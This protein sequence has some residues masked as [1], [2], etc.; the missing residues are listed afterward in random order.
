MKVMWILLASLVLVSL[1]AYFGVYYWLCN[2]GGEKVPPPSGSLP[3]SVSLLRQHVTALVSVKPARHAGNVA[4]LDKAADYIRS[5]WTTM[6]YKTKDQVFKI[7]S[8]TYRNVQTFAGPEAGPRIV[9]GAHYDVCGNQPGA[10]DN[11][12]GVAGLL[13]LSRLIKTLKPKLKY[14]IDLVAYTLEEPPH[15]GT[16]QMG[17]AVHAAELKRSGVDIIAMISLEMIGYFSNTPGSQEYPIGLLSL[18]YPTVGNF[19]A[20]VGNQTSSGRRLTQQIRQGMVSASSLPVFSLNGPSGLTGIDF[21]DHRNYWAQGFPAVM[22]TDT[23]FFRNK[24]YHQPTD[25]IDTLQFD[26][27]SQVVKGV[28]WATLNL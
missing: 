10:D 12:S 15:F 25:T 6:G 16:H 19:I 17:S 2:P 8:K 27:M 4:S 26:K 1:V 24:N 9:I 3:V 11:A 21:S 5:Q 7:G 22:V 23:A 20:V 28:Y 14:R 13:E 18:W